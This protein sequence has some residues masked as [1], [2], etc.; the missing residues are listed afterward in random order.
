MGNTKKFEL[1]ADKILENM[2]L[3]DERKKQI[4]ALA[5]VKF[6]LEQEEGFNFARGFVKGYASNVRDSEQYY[7]SAKVFNLIKACRQIVSYLNGGVSV[8]PT[9]LVHKDLET[10]LSSISPITYFAFDKNKEFVLSH[11]I[12]YCRKIEKEQKGKGVAFVKEINP[13]KNVYD[14]L[15]ACMKYPDAKVE[16]NGTKYCGESGCR[17]TEFANGYCIKHANI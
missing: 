10:A 15:M 9:S 7:D 11:L 4:K 12:D 1:E 2:G 14:V 8:N 3:S 6:D 17:E 16:F 13:T 5:I